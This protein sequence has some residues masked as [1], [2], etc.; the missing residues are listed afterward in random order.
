MFNLLKE[1]MATANLIVQQRMQIDE[2]L[3]GQLKTIFEGSNFKVPDIAHLLK[4]APAIVKGSQKLPNTLAPH[5]PNGSKLYDLAKIRRDF[6]EHATFAFVVEHKETFTK[7]KLGKALQQ[8]GVVEA[9]AKA[10]EDQRCAKCN[11][12][13]LSWSP[14]F[15]E[16]RC[17]HC[18]RQEEEA[19]AAAPTPTHAPAPTP[20]A[21]FTV[22]PPATPNST[23][24][25]SAA[26]PASTSTSN[27][28]AEKKQSEGAMDVQ[29]GQIKAKNAKSTS[30]SASSGGGGTRKTTNVFTFLIRIDGATSRVAPFLCSCFNDTVLI[31]VILF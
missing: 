12:D 11:N 10:H 2:E 23:S 21:P 13:A 30:T 14:T 1:N 3:R 25:S 22:A 7:M 17:E 28:S 16:W 18:E 15:K 8:S 20:T 4:V 31:T 26:H 29:T 27:K 9:A 19:P 6:K 24:P 5:G